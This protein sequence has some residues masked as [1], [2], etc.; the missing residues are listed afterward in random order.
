MKHPPIVRTPAAAVSRCH[1]HQSPCT[2][3]RPQQ[4]GIPYAATICY[5]D[6]GA[7][8]VVEGA[9]VRPMSRE[10][11][12]MIIVGIVLCFVGLGFLC[13]LLF[14]LLCG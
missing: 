3:Q 4:Q 2:K 8:V 11:T 9:A 14:T 10:T 7:V 13:W 6:A 5:F 12:A 1:V